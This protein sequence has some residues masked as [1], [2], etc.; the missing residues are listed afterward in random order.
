MKNILDKCEYLYSLTYLGW[1]L[2]HIGWAFVGVAFVGVAYV[3]VA[4]VGV[5]FVCTRPLYIDKGN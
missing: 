5:A 4:L 2:S 1:L 3:W